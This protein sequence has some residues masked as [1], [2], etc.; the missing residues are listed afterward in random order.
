MVAADSLTRFHLPRQLTTDPPH[1]GRVS[2]LD[3]SETQLFLP[4][5]VC[6]YIVHRTQTPVVSITQYRVCVGVCVYIVPRTQ[7]QVVSITRYRVCMCV[8]TLCIGR[9]GCFY[10]PIL[11]HFVATPHSLALY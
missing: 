7:T 3:S 1:W 6:V 5:C 9:D 8:S 10:L 4:G 2:D 11:Q